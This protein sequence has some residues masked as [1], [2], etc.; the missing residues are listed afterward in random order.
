MAGVP[1]HELYTIRSRLSGLA[2]RQKLECYSML[3][4]SLHKFEAGLT[5]EYPTYVP[6]RYAFLV[7]IR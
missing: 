7:H 6:M 5:E 3:S 1:Q 2:H 4:I